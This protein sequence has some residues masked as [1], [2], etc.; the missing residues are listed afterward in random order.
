MDTTASTTTTLKPIVDLC[1]YFLRQDPCQKNPCPHQHPLLEERPHCKS[2]ARERKCKYGS[3]CFF[4]HITPS[5][6]I[7][8]RPHT[9][10]ITQAKEVYIP[11]FRHYIKETFDINTHRSRYPGFSKVDDAIIHIDLPLEQCSQDTFVTHVESK[12]FLQNA[13]TRIYPVDTHMKEVFTNN[14]I[15][16]GD[17]QY[18]INY[19]INEIIA[20]AE[21]NNTLSVTI[22]TQCY[23]NTNEIPF[24]ETLFNI[25]NTNTIKNSK[26]ETITISLSMQGWDLM[27]YN[28]FSDG[29]Y[30]CGI[31]H[32]SSPYNIGKKRLR[33]QVEGSI[34][35]AQ[36]KLYEVS[37]RTNFLP[38]I[39]AIKN[40]SND[41]SNKS[42]KIDNNNNTVNDDTTITT[43][44][45]PKL[46]L[47]IGASPGSWSNYLAKYCGYD[48]VYAVDPGDLSSDIEKNIIHYKIKGEDALKIFKEEQILF[49]TYVCDIN[50]DM[51]YTVELCKTVL[52]YLKKHAL[53]VITLKYFQQN[54]HNYQA[55]MERSRDKLGQ[56]LQEGWKCIHLM[57]NGSHEVTVVGYMKE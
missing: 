20:Y 13:Y 50:V 19:Y 49:D 38:I 29:Y 15:G 16:I 23:P 27:L 56:Y 18:L 26:D 6:F 3:D 2:F 44:N 39:H 17:Q 41:S 7:I 21:T 47:D 14:K 30:Y 43:S 55:D 31:R 40:D 32:N 24:A 37:L 46:A 51:E 9:K 54:P 28:V 12:P 52:P 36:Y 45:S 53:L 57:A 1:T 4:Q 48:N 25:S 34:C 5:E 8:E 22:R 33:H 42:I 10:V 35:R 11:R